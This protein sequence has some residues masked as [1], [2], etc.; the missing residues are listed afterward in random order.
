MQPEPPSARRAPFCRSLHGVDR[1]DD[2]A[3]MRD[4]GAELLAH[5]RAERTYYDAATEFLRPLRDALFDEMSARVS[6]TDRSVS[7]AATRWVY[8]TE[9]PPGSEHPQLRRAVDRAA[10]DQ[11]AGTV[12]L[13]LSQL[14]GGS[15]Y[16]DLGA[17]EVS[18][19]ESLLAYSVDLSGEETY[20]LRFRELQTG[21]DLPDRLPEVAAGGVWGAEPG[22]FLY[23]RLDQAWRAYQVWRH[24]LGS[25][26][27]DDVC[28][29]TEADEKYEVSLRRC[30][31]GELVVV[32][33]AN[34]DT[35][36]EWLVDASPPPSQPRLVAARRP[37]VEYSVEHV[38]AGRDG[39]WLFLVTN[40]EAP[41]FRLMRTPVAAPG[42]EHW[43]QVVPERS[44]ERLAQ[45]D[46]FAGHLVLSVR[47]DSTPL[48]RVVPLTEDGDPEIGSDRALEL[49]PSTPAG[50][51]WLDRNERYDTGVLLAGD[52]SYVQPP[53][54]YHISLDDGARETVKRQVVPG[55][56]PAAY[57]SE[58]IQV[59]SSDGATVPVTLA[60]R[61]DVPRDGTAPCLMYGYGAYEYCFEPEFDLALVSMLDRGVVFAHA[62]VRGG[63]EGGRR[64]WLDG[65]L[66]HKQNTFTDHISAANDL[67][68]KGVVDGDRIASRGL[69]AGGLLQGAVV[70]QAPERWRAVVAEVPFVDVVTTM[71]DASIPLTAGEWDEWGDPRREADFR[72]MLAYSPYD[73]LPPPGHRP[74]L[75]VTG[76]VHDARVMVWEPAKWVSALRASDPD[77][78]PRCLFRCELGAG[79]HAGPS[80][81]YATLRYEAEIYAWLLDRLGC[82]K[83]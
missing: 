80:G 54:W 24:R 74:D 8:Y 16:A 44:D 19:D 53:T 17:C 38:R 25:P 29:F 12:L 40:D 78:S 70:S 26:P 73:N 72:W 68:A 59:P 5:C 63:G 30:R 83:S 14:A 48:L 13:D 28:V 71:L 33:T 77:W 23:L 61:K 11:G 67:A 2:Y 47:R 75:L 56:D 37:G 39:G 7:W 15:P 18:P 46:A 35:S 62:H 41:E 50:T 22:T 57:L 4:R 34:R 81:R 58:R 45:V 76:A 21:H 3:W 55:Y 79:A 36:E 20:E 31:S 82:C 27:S 42:R 32:H 65:R 64:W 9:T 6:A 60:H 43:Q 66:Q 1:I 51:I 52:Q 10:A 49:H 69:S